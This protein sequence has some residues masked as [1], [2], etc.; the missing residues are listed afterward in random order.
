MNGARNMLA[1]PLLPKPERGGHAGHQKA[2]FL[3]LA[4]CMVLYLGSGISQPLMMS[5]VRLAGMG[6][7]ACQIY[8][9]PY[10]VG[11]ACCALFMFCDPAGLPPA[12]KWQ[13]WPLRRCA[14]IA[15][16]SALAQNLNYAG[17]MLAGSGVFAIIY[18]SVTVWCA[19]LS[20][21][22]LKRV[23][24]TTQWVAVF[25]VFFGLVISGFGARSEGGQ[26]ALGVC[27]ICFGAV[28]HGCSHVLSEL[29]S[30]HGEKIPPQI[31]SAVQ[32]LTA[33]ALVGGWQIA[34]TLPHWGDISGPASEAGTSAL[35]GGKLLVGLAIGNLIHAASFFHLLAHIGATSAGLVKAVQAVAVF[36]LSHKMYCEQDPSQCLTP[37]KTLSLV[38]VVSGVLAYVFATA[39]AKKNSA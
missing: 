39:K 26:V 14:Y 34:Y 31:N 6:D 37:T 12:H 36:L 33:V 8:M 38:V 19:V 13:A 10:F 17:N 7:T 28:G 27:F 9:L 2:S 20:R 24:T 29:V 1:Q 16:L 4:V 32:G 5:A 35:H 30:T 3:S 11:Q 25:T 18:S 22:I 15:V 21:L 23:M